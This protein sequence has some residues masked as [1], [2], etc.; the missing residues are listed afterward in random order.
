MNHGSYEVIGY[1][2]A[3]LSFLFLHFK[4]DKCDP[5]HSSLRFTSMFCF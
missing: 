5:R 1:L 4:L 2:G 3:N